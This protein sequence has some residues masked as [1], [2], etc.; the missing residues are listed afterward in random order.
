[1]AKIKPIT[2]RRRLELSK[3]GGPAVQ[4]ELM[5]TDIDLK[6]FAIRLE[7]LIKTDL[8]GRIID[9][10]V[11]RTIEGAS[12]LSVEIDDYDRDVFTSYLLTERFDVE[13]DGLWFR[14]TTVEKQG[15]R[16][17]LTFQ[18]REIEILRTY[19][20]WYQ[21]S[22]DEVTRAEFV[23][24]MIREVKEFNIPV[25][26]PQL[27][28][29]QP[30]AQWSG[31]LQGTDMVLQKSQG[32][33]LDTN[34]Q[35]TAKD[36]YNHRDE[37]SA[38]SK[39]A[40]TKTGTTRLMVKTA[41]ATKEQINNA[42]IIMAVANSMGVSRQLKVCSIMTAIQES[43]ITAIPDKAHGGRS[44]GDS[45]GIFQ[46]RPGWGSYDDRMN[47]ETAA[48]D[49]FTAAI[50]VEKN[51]PGQPLWFICAETQH[52]KEEYRILYAQWRTQAERFV[53]ASGDVTDVNLA[54]NQYGTTGAYSAT[55]GPYWFYRGEVTDKRGQKVRLPENSW[56]CI[57]RLADEVDWRAFFVSGTFYFITEDDLIKQLPVAKLN[58]FSE[59]VIEL[60]GTFDN[61]RKSATVSLRVMVGRW[62]LPPGSVVVLDGCGIFDGRWIVSDYSRSLVATDRTATVTLKKPRPKLPEPDLQGNAGDLET[63]WAPTTPAAVSPVADAETA[64]LKDPRIT[65][66]NACQRSDIKFGQ[67]DNRVLQ[68]LVWLAEQGYDLIITSLKC[69]HS[70]N[71][72]AGNPSAHG[73]V[74]A[75]DIGSLS[76]TLVANNSISGQ[77][78]DLL[79]HNQLILGF[80]QL[81]GP[82]PL[83]C[84]P[85]GWYDA[86]TLAQHDDHLHIGWKI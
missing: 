47:P 85:L 21:A 68:C 49:F 16:I 67:I 62:Q 37:P 51:N 64:V 23:L 36:R 59:G 60:D 19:K 65:L 76:G 48:R 20:K 63:S 12:T 5:G 11:S 86:P 34:D 39:T 57:Q 2:A 28:M 33:P 46:Q 3:V 26:I 82:F 83:K 53:N 54:N 35:E 71:T 13:I 73:A 14:L 1:V 17:T 25:V 80:D 70:A 56:K 31:D 61:H 78:M 8:I 29:I 44:D 81:I 50:P 15:D 4:R 45:A 74:R 30:I 32:V 24:H 42:N 6:S 69:D 52:P 79:K 66:Q 58:E 18:D 10:S 40:K 55:E 77:V 22:R 38:P 41:I 72:T 7:G 84:I 75:V 27:H 9:A 43:S